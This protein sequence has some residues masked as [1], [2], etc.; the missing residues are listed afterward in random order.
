MSKMKVHCATRPIR[1]MLDIFA[2][3]CLLFSVSVLAQNEES[4]YRGRPVHEVLDQLQEGGMALIY[5][6]NLV[7]DALKVAREPVSRDPV[8]LVIEILE[9]HGLTLNE[10]DGIY[11]VVRRTQTAEP[12]QLTSILVVIS[13]VE[14]LPDK[15]MVV[16]NSAPE[17]PDAGM[18]WPGMYEFSGLEP[19]TYEIEIAATGYFSV[20]RTVELDT[21]QT[22]VLRI[23]ME[24][25]PV[26]LEELNITASRYI[27]FSNSQFFIDQRA[28]QAQPDLGEDPVRSVHRLPGAAASG[29]SS[30]SHFRGG[31]HNETAIFLNGI[32]L[33]DPFHIRNYHSIFSSID[34]RAIS[35]VEAYTGG[36]PVNYGDHMSG[37]LLLDTQKPDQPRRTEL[38]L[39]IY[40][41]SLLSSGYTSEGK[42]DWLVSARRSNLGLI[43]NKD[44]GKPNYFDVFVELGI[45]ISPDTRLSINGM[46]ADDRIEV[47]TETDPEE[48]ERSVSNTQNENFW[49]LL[50]NQWTPY[51]SSAT[52]LSY[53]ALNNEHNAEMNDPDKLV[54][55]VSDNREA[56][57]F[58]LRQDWRYDAFSRH[59]LRWGFE[60]RREKARYQYAS[61]AEYQ[62][63]FT[64]YPGIENPTESD[65]MAA[66]DG[67]A[68]SFFLTDRW[69]LAGSTALE[70]GLRW[71]RQTYTEPKFDDQLS[72]RIS[73]LHS[74]NTSI[75]LRLTWGRYYQ[76]QAIQ[77]LQVED[78]LDHFFAPQRADH[79]I[80]GVQFRYPHD[81]RL[82][83]EAFMKNYDRLK[84]RFENLFDSLALIPELQP[85][86]VRLD[87]QSGRSRGIE[88]TLEYRGN[89]ELNWWAS[90]TWAKATDRIDGRDERR[91][92]D[93][94]HA[95]QAGVAWQ[96]GLW[97]LGV[98]VSVHSGWPITSMEL[99]MVP[100]EGDDGDQLGDE[101]G[102]EPGD[103]L[104]EDDENGDYEYFPIPGPRNAQQLGT[105]ATLDFRISREFPVKIGRLSGFFEVTN[106]TNRR[107]ECCIDYDLDEDDDGNIFL[108]GAV[109]YWLPVIPAIGV[110]WEF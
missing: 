96:R 60:I 66:P 64:L 26:E 25:S 44:L 109:D 50:E 45:N 6:T 74:L 30:R 71:D 12:E 79:W 58:S 75:D 51:L 77:N 14:S 63:F 52:V 10:I 107:N 9:P 55:A 20:H 29:L 93:Q 67:G 106:A 100:S 28:I 81:Y 68:Y 18:L 24:L 82:R 21:G 97:E 86:R 101:P 69:Q 48:L 43:L 4:S 15:G 3:A 83:V 73:L 57:I 39:S 38:G 16:I 89:E 110:L 61:E 22:R 8:E 46:Y 40:N 87:P 47:V 23:Q 91:S 37:V 85:D 1:L 34:A 2:C 104:G 72:P 53:S 11:L 36:F 92:W 7:T 98:A 27:L 76:S 49:L 31:E 84:P 88:L 59:I 35:G 103:E 65:I 56:K 80:A 105:F 102:D 19:G 62:E 90:Y 54:G 33:L 95:L 108:D 5:S 78:G 70:L 99:G 42:V 13:N 32:Q 41:T 17:L 94:R